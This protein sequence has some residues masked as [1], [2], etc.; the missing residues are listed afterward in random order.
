MTCPSSP[1]ALRLAADDVEKGSF[2]ILRAYCHLFGQQAPL[3]LA[4]FISDLE[5]RHASLLAQLPEEGQ[6]RY[7]AR[8]KDAAESEGALRW[9]IPGAASREVDAAAAQADPSLLTLQ[10]CYMTKLPSELSMAV[11]PS[12]T[13]S[14]TLPNPHTIHQKEI[15]LL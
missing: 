2:N 9:V 4:A 6:Q 7:K 1:N 15:G 14:M 10:P 3:R 5:T 8:Q 11:T 12:D 13:S